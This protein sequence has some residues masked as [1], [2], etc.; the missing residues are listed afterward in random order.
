VL[1]ARPAAPGE[2]AAQRLPGAV[3]PYAGVPRRD[4]HLL[5]E[6]ADTEAIEFDTAK[7]CA[8]LGLEGVYQGMSAQGQAAPQVQLQ[9]QEQ[10]WVVAVVSVIIVLR[11]GVGCR[12]WSIVAFIP[13][14]ARP[15]EPLQPSAAQPIVCVDAL[16]SHRRLTTQLPQIGS[17]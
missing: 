17:S 10:P 13:A 5:G 15:G 4:P 3:Q 12:A 1:E 6:G 16:P 2:L 8:V 7:S 11:F 9:P 14:D